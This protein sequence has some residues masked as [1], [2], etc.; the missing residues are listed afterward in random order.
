MDL[1]KNI[2]APTDFSSG[3]EIAIQYA[4]NLAKQSAA[5]LHLLHVSMLLGS[6]VVQSGNI[7]VVRA[8]N[9]DSVLI[10]PGNGYTMVL[11]EILLEKKSRKSAT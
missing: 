1:I 3:S 7:N 11:D 9:L 8:Q 4:C 10:T 5:K 2:L 6:S